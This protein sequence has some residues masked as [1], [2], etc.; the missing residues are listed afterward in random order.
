MTQ[1]H[2][3]AK[4]QCTDGPGGQ[5][6]AVVVD[7][8][9]TAVTHLAVKGD[10][11]ANYMVPLSHVSDSSR[12][13][14]QLDCSVAELRGMYP[15]T[16]THYINSSDDTQTN[17]YPY[18]VGDIYMSP[19]VLPAEMSI[20]Y[21]EEDCIPP[22]ELAFRRGASIVA[23][24]GSI[25]KVDEFVLSPDTGH[26]SHIVMREGHFWGKHDVMIPMTAVDRFDG[27]TVHLS[28]DKEAVKALPSVPVKRSW[29]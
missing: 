7:P 18:M 29:F 23:T 13:L 14:I 11:A 8:T 9:T 16:E 10:M 15:F 19:Y 2:I 27:E 17:P 22:N 12:D 5:A 24:D 28:L 25:G 3:G 6:L 4:V 21:V 1:L 26:I 20:P